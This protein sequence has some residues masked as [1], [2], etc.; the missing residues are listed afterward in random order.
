MSVEI[1][2]RQL[3]KQSVSATD[4]P[5][6]LMS[7]PSQ[8]PLPSSS[9]SPSPSNS[10]ANQIEGY[11][12]DFSNGVEFFAPFV[13]GTSQFYEVYDQGPN[14]PVAV[15]ES[16]VVSINQDGSN[17][18][19]LFQGLNFGPNFQSQLT[20]TLSNGQLTVLFPQSDGSLNSVTFQPRTIGQYNQAVHQLKEQV[21]QQ[22]QALAQQAQIS[23]EQQT[24]SNDAQTVPADL[25]SEQ[26]GQNSI[27][28][29][30]SAMNQDLQSE[31]ADLVT[32]ANQ[33]QAEE[34]LAEQYP[35]G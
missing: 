33:L 34:V 31:T 29:A 25:Q 26:S 1:R 12:A 4:S 14:N 6:V 7:S 8:S 28:A 30:L 22:Q 23:N 16:S 5:S 13:N 3:K 9:P 20:G 10:T 17:V 21:N 15:T 18:Q 11:I 32:T 35:K 2:L 19:I 27:T 24:I